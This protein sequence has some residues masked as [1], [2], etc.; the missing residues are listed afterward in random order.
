[1]CLWS[2][3]Y[4][5]YE[6]A[7]WEHFFG[8][9]CYGKTSITLIGFLKMV[10]YLNLVNAMPRESHVRRTHQLKSLLV[11]IRFYVC[12][13]QICPGRIRA[14]LLSR[15]TT[16]PLFGGHVLLFHKNEIFSKDIKK[17]QN[18]P[19]RG[20]LATVRSPLANTQKRLEKW[21][22]IRLWMAILKP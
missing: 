5:S 9:L 15:A 1:M 13:T 10:R 16:H 3:R 2:W 20:P 7:R 8:I 22:W 11:T 4:V 18:V 19:E 17:C 21:W 14:A 12:L 6:S